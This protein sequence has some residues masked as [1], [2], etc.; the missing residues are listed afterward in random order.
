MK[1]K[2]LTIKQ[3]YEKERG[4]FGRNVKRIVANKTKT[5]IRHLFFGL[6]HIFGMAHSLSEE[7]DK[8]PRNI[9]VQTGA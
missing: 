8:L 1:S 9:I 2:A 6:A 5:L 3:K 4:K 7:G